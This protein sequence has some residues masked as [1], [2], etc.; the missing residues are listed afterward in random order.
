[1]LQGVSRSVMEP[2][3][4]VTERVER[5]TVNWEIN[6]KLL[7]ILATDPKNLSLRELLTFIGYL[8]GNGLDTRTYR[9]AFWSKIIAPLTNLA[10]L[11]IAMPFVFGPQRTAGFGQRLV[12]G[13]FIGLIFYLLNRMLGNLVL[14]YDF[15]PWFG[16]GLPTLLFFA[17]GTYTLRRIR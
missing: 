11:F 12:I 3:Q 16:A 7:K 2:E 5:L 10:M 1:M 9:L 4:V 15:P 17:A 8:E 13:V 6:P 14:L